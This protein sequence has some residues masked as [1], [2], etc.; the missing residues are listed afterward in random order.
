MP[1]IIIDNR[2]SKE[3]VKE[4]IKHNIDA[5]IKQLAI[6]DFVIQTK[7]LDNKIQTIGIERK[8][9][10]DFLNSI[11]DRRLLN[12]LIILKENFDIPLIILEGDENIY[13]M[14]DFHPNSIRGMLATIAVDFQIPIIP[15][16]N[17]RDT[18][19]FLS[20]LA[21]RLE[22]QRKPISLLKKRKPLTIREQQEYL[23]ESFPSIGPNTAKRL[24]NH[25][26]SVKSIMNASEKEMQGVENIGKNKAGKIKKIIKSNY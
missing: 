18:A 11:I 17:H 24:L 8:T 22:K 4:I 1:K 20:I 7:T 13:Q 23:I 14:R 21:K 15:T 10:N 12:Q 3:I 16:L 5:E 25:F 9:K 19:S 26:K 6:A 2:E